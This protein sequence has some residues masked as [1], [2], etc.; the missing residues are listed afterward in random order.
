MNA[1][2]EVER[3]R[4][5]ARANA[6]EALVFASAVLLGAWVFCYELGI[7]R[8]HLAVQEL[9]VA[10][11][12]VGIGWALVVS[13]WWLH[14]DAAESLGLGHPREVWRR[15][16]HGRW[17]TTAVVLGM[18]ASLLAVGMTHW[19]LTARFFKLPSAALLW[20]ETAG[21]QTLI[22]LF[23]ALVAGVFVTCFIRYD[24]FG[25]SLR[26]AAK[27][28]WPLVP[29]AVVIAYAHRGADAFAVL[30]S[31]REWLEIVAYVFWGGM[32]QILF[33]GWFGTRIRKGFGLARSRVGRLAVAVL[34]ASFFALIHLPSYR[35]VAVTLVLGTIFAWLAMEDRHRNLAA[36][37]IVHGV[38]GATVA[39]LFSGEAAG[40]LRIRFRVG[41]WNAAGDPAVTWVAVACVCVYVAGVA[42]VMR[43]RP[44]APP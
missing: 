14:G 3:D 42:S 17:G 21:G 8:A 22:L 27:A 36:F 44:T 20:R 5:S 1:A 32:Q 2:G 6:I 16:K 19:R 43:R 23:C 30:A 41:P 10:L 33:T 11:L 35:L 18:F 40:A 4:C 26:A 12:K 29:L 9:S 25:S 7:V 34:S 15:M 31:S 37:A 28:A 38:L 24:N 13:P 39:K